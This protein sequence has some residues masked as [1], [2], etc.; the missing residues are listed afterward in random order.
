MAS[1]K[2]SNIDKAG[3]AA[4]ASSFRIQQPQTASVALE[5]AGTSELIQ[6]NFS[7]KAVEQM[8]RK[9][10]GFSVTREK[11]KPREVIEQATIY[12]TEKRV[13]IPP[14]AFKKAMLTAS[15]QVKTFKKTQLR[16]ALF[17]EGSSIPITYDKMV[18]RMDM[19]RTAGMARTPDVRFR[20]SFH[21]W[22]ARI[23]VKFS[24]ALSVESVVDLLN[25]AGDVGV[26]E[27]R[28]EK[29]GTFGK[30]RVVR[31]IVDVKELEQVRAEC[32]I[33]LVALKIPDWALDADIDPETLS[34]IFDQQEEE[35]EE[36]P[37]RKSN[38][39]RAE[40]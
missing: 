13:C 9:H 25:R 11:K 8:L 1:K 26:G 39:A 35:G 24:D 31:N 27:W 23:V 6:N 7:Q 28:P 4:T 22:K 3:K 20:P 18:P 36:K 2:K 33:P 37:R 10:M 14:T 32:A 21:G 15:A 40:V 30:F 38:G 34:E 16:I 19:V 29:D 17:V 12:N 5:V